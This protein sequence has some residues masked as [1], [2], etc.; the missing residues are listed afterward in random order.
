ML[1]ESYTLRDSSSEQKKKLSG[2]KNKGKEGAENRRKKIER[3]EKKSGE[4]ITAQISSQDTP[5]S[6]RI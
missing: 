2:K 1:N 4:R 5:V 3:E 6:L